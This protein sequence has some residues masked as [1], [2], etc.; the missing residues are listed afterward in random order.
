MK[1]Q[2][3][4]SI[5]VEVVVMINDLIHVLLVLTAPNTQNSV[6]NCFMFPSSAVKEL[7]RFSFPCKFYMSAPR[8]ELSASFPINKKKKKRKIR[9]LFRV[10]KLGSLEN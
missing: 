8:A 10:S 2:T 9:D 6:I 1:V 7:N 3:K 5:C 4:L